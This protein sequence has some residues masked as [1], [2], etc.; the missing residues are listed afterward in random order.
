MTSHTHKLADRFVLRAPVLPFATLEHLDARALLADPGIREALFIA[1]PELTTALET[2]SSDPAVLRSAIRYLSRMAFR[3]TPFGLFSGVG[4][5]TFGDATELRL[6]ARGD[7]TRHTRLDND[8]LAKL[9]D[10]IA[11]DPMM[12]RELTFVPTTSLYRAGEK[13]RFA[14]SRL[15]RD[16]REYDLVATEIS[17]HL[18]VVLER[19]RGGATLE[20]LAC[21][22]ATS[23]PELTREEVDHYLDELVRVQMLVPT[24][25]PRV[26]GPEPAEVMRTMLEA[27][28]SARGVASVL[29]DVDGRLAAIDDA[30]GAAPET[31][32]AIAVALQPLPAPVSIA[33]LFQVDVALRFS[34]ATLGPRVASEITRA[35]E[36]VRKLTPPRR[37]SAWATFR[38]RFLARYE[39]REVPLVEVLD[40]ESGIGFGAPA[41]DTAQAP[42][43]RDLAFPSAPPTETSWTERDTTLLRLLGESR[44]APELVLSNADVAALE[45]EPAELA[46]T[47]SFTVRL[48]AASREAIARG[49]LTIDAGTVGGASAT[50]LLGRFCHASREVHS[51]VED[52]ARREQALAGDAILAEIV[53]LPEGRLGNILLRP[54]LRSWEI[55]YMGVSGARA[56]HQIAITDL[57]VSVRGDR[58]VVRSQRLGREVRPHIATAH[59]FGMRSLAIYRFLCAH[60]SQHAESG[61]WSWG[62]L[63]AAPFLPRVRHGKVVLARASWRILKPDLQGLGGTAEARTLRDRYRLPRWM[64]LADSDNELPVDFESDAS[65]DGFVQL[66]RTREAI[67]LVEMHPAPDQLV[68]DGTGGMHTH[69]IV[70]AFVREHPAPQ[71]THDVP[72]VT[73]ERRFPP[74]SRWLYA[75]LYGGTATLDGVLRDAIAPLARDLLR[76]GLANRWFFVR[77]ADP[78]DH[79]RVRFHGDP[80]ILL[81][82]VL[83]RLTRIADTGLIW[84]LQLDTYEREVERYGGDRGIEISEQVFAADSNAAIT[85]IEHT[86]GDDGAEV[87]WKLAVLGLDLLARDLGLSIPERLRFAT[88]VRS[89]FATEHRIDTAFQKRLGHKFR[90]HSL[91]IAALLATRLDD[92]DH[93]YAPA[94]EA[95][96]ERSSKIAPF[97]AELRATVSSVEDVL[98]SYW[99]MHVNRMLPSMQRRQELVI[100]DLLRR[101]YDGVLARGSAATQAT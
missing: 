86:P 57:L 99:H 48:G 1:S 64:L 100:Y 34:A 61:Q 96:A 2:G 89:G 70:V 67:R 55:A 14:A 42:L 39:T 78:D 9:C 92:S 88:R 30:H 38:D 90:T 18:D 69:E 83:P 6:A 95:F 72:R 32:R 56:D 94:L 75:K 79:I 10:A 41:R 53:H 87:R 62:A 50:R 35:F 98:A 68:L 19:A 74:G 31:Y 81:R 63:E 23:D 29:G 49:E 33:R 8:Y 71:R 27:L 4:I 26:T 45:R 17:Q 3:A 20:H 76:T 24:L 21:A 47:V 91:E 16:V 15:V 85:V 82:E 77:Y 44:G 11:A 7:H 73:V 43:I 80:D 22:L 93:D 84:R 5:G 52:L 36:L 12:R 97:A 40:E 60:A 65:L 46:D 51:L 13:Y 54:V 101:H 28:P 37:D 25:Q 58:V 66:V 59:N